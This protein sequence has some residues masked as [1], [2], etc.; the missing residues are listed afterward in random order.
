MAYNNLR[1]GDAV[2]THQGFIFY[3]FG[4]EH[5]ATSYHAFLKYVPKEFAS[6]FNIDWLDIEWCFKNRI[7][8]RP[9]ELYNPENYHSLLETF[10]KEYPMFTFFSP[11]LSRWIISVS[12]K[13][14]CEV[15]TPSKRLLLLLRRSPKT[16]LEEKAI[17]LI[18]L[19]SEKSRVPIGFFGVH[20]SI[21]LEMSRKESDI[22]I[23]VYGGDNYRLVKEALAGLR[24]QSMV[25]LSTDTWYDARR[26]NK[27]IFQDTNFIINATR[28]FSEIR[29]INSTVKP[30]GK[31]K[32]ECK[33][34]NS[35]EGVFRPAIYHVSDCHSINGDVYDLSKVSQV[36]SMVGLYRDVVKDGERII[37]QGVLE[38]VLDQGN[39]VF[40]IVVG[41]GSRDEGILISKDYT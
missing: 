6:R 23:S 25:E 30:L 7:M 3:V 21:S 22:D 11:E 38:E 9:K 8:K 24:E 28:R 37:A 13:T 17:E 29:R 36:V 31:V 34:I 26:L 18:K 33:C 14:I 27:G 1:D 12:K 10:L 15:Y 4:Y 20:G 2:I 32:V 16:K 19:I 5:P 41:S 39:K 40:R 35:K